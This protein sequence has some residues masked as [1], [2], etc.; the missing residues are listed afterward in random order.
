VIALAPAAPLVAAMVLGVLTARR[1][2]PSERTVVLIAHTGMWLSALGILLGLAALSWNGLAPIDVRLGY[3][4]KAGDYEFP[5]VFL[6]DRVSFF[7]GAVILVLL[8][9][10]SKFSVHYLHREPGFARFFVLVLVFAAGIELLVFGGSLDLLLAGW[11]MVGMTSVLL[12]GFFHER[13]SPVRAAA[14]V[15]ITY[16]LCD[17]GLL[18]AAVELHLSVHT[19][20][21]SEVFG[22]EHIGAIGIV[23]GLGALVAAMGKSAQFPVGGWLPRAM[24]GP[25]AS[26]A[27]FYG[28][29]SVHAGVYLLIR[30]EPIIQAS[31]PT[32][33]GLI[34]IGLLTAV[35]A[36]LSARVS[37]DAKSAL[38]YA[39]ISQVGL[40]FVECGAGFYRLATLHLVAH[41]VLRYY[42][43]LRTPSALQD[44]LESRIAVGA[45]PARTRWEGYGKTWQRYL[46]RLAVERF[47]VEAVLERGLAQPVVRLALALARAEYLLLS[48]FDRQRS[49][50]QPSS[51]EKSA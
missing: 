45:D 28:G 6:I 37:A 36:S 15:L 18:L 5:L 34:V 12:V 9:A 10:T 50:D 19:T 44:A 23:V 39:T 29:L 47:E 26:S 11:E 7:V 38:A 1:K 35:M 32:R 2:S 51:S 17:I 43:F 33:V 40:M 24:E 42:Q 46:Y 13:T 27:V 49:S 22:H 48:Q 30:M 21:Y 16:R 41:T 14:R 3:W 20:V 4:F 31:W 8:L 25:T